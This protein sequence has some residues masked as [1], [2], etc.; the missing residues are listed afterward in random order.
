MQKFENHE[1]MREYVQKERQRLDERKNKIK[2]I[3]SN[4][5]YINWLQKFTLTYPKF[6]NDDFINNKDKLEESD[7]KNID[8]V[9]LLYYG[10]KDYANS[11]YIY[12]FIDSDFVKYYR[13]KYNNIGYEIGMIIGQETLF[14]CERVDNIDNTFIDFNNIILNKKEENTK[15]IEERLNELSNTIT[16]LHEQNIPL[17]II[18][19]IIDDNI[20]NIEEKSKIKS[21]IYRR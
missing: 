1:Q 16:C 10:I 14:F 6:R 2:E 4:N 13:I 18:K 21:K 3:I 15:F 20:F 11:N 12:P 19:S 17:D 8:N 5:N 7:L 9:S